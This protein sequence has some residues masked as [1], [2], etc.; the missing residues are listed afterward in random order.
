MKIEK[1]KKSVV[2]DKAEKSI[3]YIIVQI[4]KSKYCFMWLSFVLANLDD[5]DNKRAWGCVAQCQMFEVLDLNGVLNT[6][7]FKLEYIINSKNF[8]SRRIFK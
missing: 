8:F 6:L 4:Y 7:E 5:N 1:W 2:Y 3:I